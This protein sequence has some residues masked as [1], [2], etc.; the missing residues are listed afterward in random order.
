MF[1]PPLVAV[2]IKIQAMMKQLAI[3]L[4]FIAVELYHISPTLK[5]AGL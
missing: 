1:N 4:Y 5:P 2:A 3:K